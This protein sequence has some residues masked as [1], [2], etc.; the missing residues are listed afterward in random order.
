MITLL[1]CYSTDRF[2]SLFPILSVEEQNFATR[3]GAK[4]HFNSL[5]YMEKM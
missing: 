1:F 4:L 2:Q 3:T 5:K